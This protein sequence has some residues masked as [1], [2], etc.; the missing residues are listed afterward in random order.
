M[1][2]MF[3][4]ECVYKGYSEENYRE[5]MGVL[6]QNHIKFKN[7]CKVANP[8]SYRMGNLGEIGKYQYIYEI[9]VHKDDFELCQ[10][11]I[12]KNKENKK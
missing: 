1:I 6:S 4:Q 7:N 9:Y 3:N 10:F 11:L 12:R 8:S 5:V 2:T